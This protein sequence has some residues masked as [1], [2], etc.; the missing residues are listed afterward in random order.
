MGPTST[1]GG[2]VDHRAVIGHAP[3]SR[4]WVPGVPTFG[5]VLEEDVRV[6]PFATIDAGMKR[7]TIIGARTWC[8][9]R[10]HVG[11]DVQIGTDCELS[12]GCIVGGHCTIG[13]GVRIGIGAV[14]RPWVKVGD[15]A[16]IG[17]GAVVVKDVPAGE[18]WAGNPAKCLSRA[19]CGCT[20]PLDCDDRDGCGV[21]EVAA[22]AGAYTEAGYARR[23]DMRV[24]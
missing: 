20:H 9:K 24:A 16:R 14:L 23:R 12:T 11:H 1:H 2:K 19:K 18:V 17:C 7:P 8:F 4:D 21:R 5:V 13:N 15:G 10:C 3:E 6:E 22:I